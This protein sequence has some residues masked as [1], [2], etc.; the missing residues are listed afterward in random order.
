MSVGHRVVDDAFR[1]ADIAGLRAASGGSSPSEDALGGGPRAQRW[2]AC[3][4]L[5]PTLPS[6]RCRR[7]H[8]ELHAAGDARV[9]SRRTCP[10]AA[11]TSTRV[12]RLSLGLRVVL[13]VDAG[14][15]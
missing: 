10:P 7:Q 1:A 2:C 14:H 6:D 8:A 12:R 4:E 9:S 3:A 13:A 5:L 11:P 15:A